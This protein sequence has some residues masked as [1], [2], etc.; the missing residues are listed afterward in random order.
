MRAPAERGGLAENK[1][2]LLQRDSVANILDYKP[3]PVTFIM[4][5]EEAAR[6]TDYVVLRSAM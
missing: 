3:I 6:A 2:S 1:G 4:N 5:Q